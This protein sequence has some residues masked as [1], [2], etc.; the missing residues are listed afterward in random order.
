MPESFTLEQPTEYD[1]SHKTVT[2]SVLHSSGLSKWTV[3]L[4]DTN[5]FAPGWSGPVNCVLFGGN[6]FSLR[7]YNGGILTYIAAKVEIGP[8]QTLAKRDSDGNW[9]LND[10]PPNKAEMLAKCQ[11]YFDIIQSRIH[12]NTTEVVYFHQH[13]RAIPTIYV[14][15]PLGTISTYLSNSDSGYTTQDIAWINNTDPSYSRGGYIIADANL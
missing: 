14:Q 10:P 3:N 9:V 15:E 5:S 13:M 7:F 2:I 6:T 1:L 4:G 11:R 8:Q 12:S